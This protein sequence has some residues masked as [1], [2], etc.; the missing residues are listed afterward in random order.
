MSLWTNAAS[1]CE[2]EQ[3]KRCHAGIVCC[4][5]EVAVEA[6]LASIARRTLNIQTL[7]PRKLDALDF[8]EVAVGQVLAALSLSY[9]LGRGRQKH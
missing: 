3:L 1:L 4:E 9:R 5:Q 6:E 8:R 7:A 2:G